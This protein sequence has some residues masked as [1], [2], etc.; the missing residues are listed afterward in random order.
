[1]KIIITG[2]IGIGKTTFLNAL[3][4]Q[5]NLSDKIFGFITEKHLYN[6][7]IVDVG[8]VNISPPCH[9]QII[10]DKHCVAELIGNNEWICHQEVFETIGVSL[11]SNIPKGSLVIMDEI[12]FLESNAQNFSQKIRE[13]IDGDYNIIAVIKPQSTSLLDYIR[14]KKDILLYDITLENRNQLRSQVNDIAKN[15]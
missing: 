5:L 1:M 15:F 11:L 9:E 14:N 6:K 3:I 7:Q 12:G 13:I 4:A 2:R 8:K 10:S